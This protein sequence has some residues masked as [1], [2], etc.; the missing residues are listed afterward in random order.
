MIL[1]FTLMIINFITWFAVSVML[2]RSSWSLWMNTTTIEG[3]EIERHRTLFRRAKAFG[4]YLDG[5]NGV[6]IRIKK[7]EFPFDIGILANLNQGMGGN[8]LTWFLPI[9]PTPSN[10]SGLDFE[11]NG[12]ESMCV[13]AA[14]YTLLIPYRS[15]YHVATSR[16]GQN[17]SGTSVLCI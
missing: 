9:A 3:W 16:P 7:Q 15:V 12:F 14:R 10:K 11:V 5:P 17:A 2:L 8:I 6:K 4:G 1:L 13:R